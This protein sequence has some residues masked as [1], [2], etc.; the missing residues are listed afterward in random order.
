MKS[1]YI[2]RPVQIFDVPI[3]EKPE[4]GFVYNFFL[5]DERVNETPPNLKTSF[6]KLSE[7]DIQQ[8]IPRY[9]TV[10]W[11]KATFDKIHATELQVDH[12]MI[13]NNSNKIIDE[14]NILQDFTMFYFQD[15]DFINRIGKRFESSAKMR[16]FV[17]GSGT[18][19]AANLMMSRADSFSTSITSNGDTTELKNQGV[20]IQRY[21]SAALQSRNFI[22]K[23]GMLIEP[24]DAAADD[25]IAMVVDNS[26]SLKSSRYSAFSPVSSA[27][28]AF[29]KNTRE[30]ASKMKKRKDK[31]MNSDESDITFPSITQEKISS[32][33]NSFPKIFH[34]GH[35]L[36]R[37]E[38][39]NQDVI[40][41]KK[42]R[43][44]TNPNV[45]SFVDLE[46]KYGAEYVY[47]VRSLIMMTA[48]TVIDKEFY[49]ST[50][51]ITSRPSTFS[52]IIGEEHVPPPV[53]PDFNFHWD[54]QNASLQLNWSFP[55]NKQRDIKGWQ[56]FRRSSIKDPYSL[57][58]Y[59]DFDDSV[60]RS[61]MYETIDK[62]LI[63]R[64]ESST[65]FFIDNEFDKD[66]DY[67][68]SICAVDA[69][70]MT[71]NYSQQFRVKFDRIQNK[72][73]KDL[74]SQSGAPK[75]Y[76]NMF[77]KRE[78]SLDSV[79]SSKCS[80]MRVYFDPEYL[81]VTNNEG[82]DLQ[83]LKMQTRNGLY[84]IMMLNTDRQLQSNIDINIL[85]LR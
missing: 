31:M 17:S 79:K 70:G 78:L 27:A 63:K 1:T 47:S 16:G 62:S 85:D 10:S 28:L 80:K 5:K 21:I 65:S 11:K 13:E 75:Q 59:L 76:P 43:Y 83:F 32:A 29:R 8:M 12:S 44:F 48:T 56:V 60:I 34:I 4:L 66:S 3:P 50:F 69:H 25:Q 2:S 41:S 71:S 54:Y 38:V 33:D 39:G 40:G 77:L 81:K 45:T 42:I 9:I 35:V 19:L 30:M 82:N 73:M 55:I 23:D 15:M 7:R 18:D 58:A 61:P 22:L 53:P 36:E 20:V 14:S 51:L 57:I 46:V 49:R 72:I 67:I 84:K 26:Y 52:S 6:N 74:I 68:Y 24:S 37:Y 64:F